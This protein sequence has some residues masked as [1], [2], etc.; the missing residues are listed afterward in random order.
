MGQPSHAYT[1]VCL[2]RRQLA[3]WYGWHSAVMTLGVLSL[4][5][6]VEFMRMSDRVW[7]FG[8]DDT[9]YL[10]ISAPVDSDRVLRDVALRAVFALLQRR[11]DYTNDRALQFIFDK[12]GY[13]Q[14]RSH[15]DS[16][17]EIFQERELRQEVTIQT[18]EYQP[19]G[20]GWIVLIQ[21]ILDRNG[22]YFGL[23]YHQRRDFALM[24]RLLRSETEFELPFR[25]NGMRYF[26][27]EAT[28]AGQ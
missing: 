25:V 27:Q 23:P 24:L 18:V 28:D 7:V 10:G 17:T 11:Y 15:L 4:F 9:L 20:S 8:Q 22:R 14:A 2:E 13:G 26:E 3:G 6:S 12:R 21:G 1:Q 19:E 5:F 16:Y